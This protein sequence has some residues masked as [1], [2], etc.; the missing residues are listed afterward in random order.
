MDL[1]G[2]LAQ[3]KLNNQLS[4]INKVLELAELGRYIEAAEFLDAIDFEEFRR[5]EDAAIF[6]YIYYR[7]ALFH[8]ARGSFEEAELDLVQST[9]FSNLPEIQ[10]KLQEDRLTARRKT[11]SSSEINDLISEVEKI[12]GKKYS[13]INLLE[14][15]KKRWKLDTPKRSLKIK[16]IDGYSCIGVY[17]WSSDQNRNQLM[18]HFI[19]ELKSGDPVVPKW[20]SLLLAKHI[21]MTPSCKSWLDEID[22]LMPVPSD[23]QRIAER[24]IDITKVV[25]K[26]LRNLIGIPCRSDTIKRKSGSPHSNTTSLSDL[27]GQY[28]FQGKKGSSIKDRVIL[29]LDDV[30]TRG[31]TARVCAELL[32]E[33]GCSR[34]FLLAIAQSESTRVSQEYA[35][36]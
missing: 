29:L 17:R 4:K 32:K 24:G 13:E 7:R 31:Y 23:P 36:D 27:R 34:I 15:W 16:D 20:F 21:N 19:R 9:K 28:E 5:H 30:V 11:Y 35:E 18:S 2:G 3:L 12:F 1:K 22:Y 14:E 6:S 8:Q 10:R 33:N 25:S 26:H